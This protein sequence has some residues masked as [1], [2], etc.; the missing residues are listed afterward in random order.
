M[1][2]AMKLIHALK[3]M[4]EMLGKKDVP[5]YW[6]VLVL[7]VYEAGEIGITTKEAAEAINMTQGIASRT[8]KLLS[9]YVDPTT[10]EVAGHDIL[11]ALQND[12]HYRHRQ[13]I[14]L[15]EHGKHVVKEMLL[16]LEK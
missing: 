1:K 14:Y 13:R 16:R 15:T 4:C 11:I 12:I 2:S 7:I 9:R 5:L 3:F 6:V 8:V 10:G